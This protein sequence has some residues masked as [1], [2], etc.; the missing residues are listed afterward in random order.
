[1]PSKGRKNHLVH[2][3][4][5]ENPSRL[6]GFPEENT[7]WQ[8]KRDNKMPYVKGKY[9]ANPSR[10]VYTCHTLFFGC[11]FFPGSPKESVNF[12]PE[13]PLRGRAESSSCKSMNFWPSTSIGSKA[14]A[15]CSFSGKVNIFLRWTGR[16]V[17]DDWGWWCGWPW[18]WLWWWWWW[19]SLQRHSCLCWCCHF[20]PFILPCPSGWFKRIDKPKLKGAGIPSKKSKVV[21]SPGSSCQSIFHNSYDWIIWPQN[22]N[23]LSPAHKFKPTGRLYPN[24]ICCCGPGKT[25]ASQTTCIAKIIWWRFHCNRSSMSSSENIFI[26]RLKWSVPCSWGFP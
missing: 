21:N 15:V 20:P 6:G 26:L 17:D 7:Q 11:F 19:W 4:P 10:V 22:A 13:Q 18:G 23:T 16:V 3:F 24:F 5:Y 12:F 25:C 8:K 14:G 2:G 1:M 9:V